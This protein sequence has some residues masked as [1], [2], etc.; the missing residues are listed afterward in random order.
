M[1]Y[2]NSKIE[3]NDSVKRSSSVNKSKS[4]KKKQRSNTTEVINNKKGIKEKNQ[5]KTN[6]IRLKVEKEI[7]NIFE[8]LPEDYEV[9]PEIRNKFE[10]IIKNI[11]DIK[12]SMNKTAHKNFYPRKSRFDGKNIHWNIFVN[13]KRI[14]LLMN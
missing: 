5:N 4:A 7:N 1:N 14:F 2:K 9:V 13:K 6:I 11:N 10:L 3:K 8:N 12:Y